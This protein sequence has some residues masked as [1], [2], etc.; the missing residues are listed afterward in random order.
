MLVSVDTFWFVGME[1]CPYVESV[2]RWELVYGTKRIFQ[3]TI[4]KNLSLVS[5]KHK[6]SVIDPILMKLEIWHLRQILLP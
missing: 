1:R 3:Q 5:L 6:S 2:R 4:K